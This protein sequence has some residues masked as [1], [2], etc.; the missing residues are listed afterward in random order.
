MASA[1]GHLDIVKLLIEKNIDLN[2]Q[3]DS[4]NTALRINI[5]KY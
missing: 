2:S 3:N 1:N 4:G 5:K